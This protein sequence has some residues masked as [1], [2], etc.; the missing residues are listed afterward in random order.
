VYKI[1][2]KSD[3]Y[4]LKYGDISIFKMAALRHLGIV[5]PPYETTHE[6][7]VAGRSCLSNF[8]SIR[9]TELFEFFEYLARNAYSG[10]QN[11]DFGGLWSWTNVIIIETPQKHIL[12]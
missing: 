12:A 9:Y 4:L 3:D 7:S 1:S 5:L 2:S 11:G 10:P 6:V 8:M